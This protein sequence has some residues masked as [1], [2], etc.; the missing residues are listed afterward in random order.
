MKII[1][2]KSR[3]E[4]FSDSVFAF[5]ATLLVV[6]LEVPKEFGELND[7]KYGFISFGISFFAL[8][9]LWKVHYNFF[10]RIKEIDNII[11]TLNMILLFVILFYVYPL[12]FLTNS[13]IGNSVFNSVDELA[14]VFQ[15]YSIGF[16]LIFVVVAL[17]YKH[18][19]KNKNLTSNEK[20]FLKQ[21]AR[22]FWIFV[23]VG[24]LS[25]LIAFL[26][27]GLKFGLPG[28]VYPLL[29]PLCWWHGK[30]SEKKYPL[31][32]H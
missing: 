22:H 28:F 6:T 2:S 13:T 18:A 32:D 3:L 19:S 27:I 29:G 12:K 4:G 30:W 1:H 5:A 25:F 16:V 23:F 10:R 17:L 9:L 15:M 20:L 24:T 8:A 11:I 14:S 31:P 26:M 21:Y 7:L